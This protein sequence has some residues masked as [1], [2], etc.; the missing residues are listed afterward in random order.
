MN[1]LDLD[2]YLITICNDDCVLTLK[3]TLDI[4]NILISLP[5]IF[6]QNLTVKR[7]KV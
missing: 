6:S 2:F 1:H 4:C 7:K 5:I 3:N